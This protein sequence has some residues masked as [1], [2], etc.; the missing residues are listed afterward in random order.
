MIDLF[1]KLQMDLLLFATEAETLQVS[2]L[3]VV[4]IQEGSPVSRHTEFF[5]FFC[6]H[7]EFLLTALFIRGVWFPDYIVG[8]LRR[9]RWLR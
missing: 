8:S 3:S 9:L 2:Q 4:A 5:D 1:V 7:T 6:R